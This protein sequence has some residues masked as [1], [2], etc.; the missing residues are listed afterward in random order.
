LNQSTHVNHAKQLSPL[1]FPIVKQRRSD[2]AKAMKRKDSAS[3][4]DHST[5]RFFPGVTVPKFCDAEPCGSNVGPMYSRVG[6]LGEHPD[7]TP[8]S[9]LVPE[10]VAGQKNI[11]QVSESEV[12]LIF[13]TII[14]HGY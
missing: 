1:D 9:S 7:A 8:K 10:T 6:A 11:Q 5:S 3:C 14:T 2:V 13:V 4:K 12:W